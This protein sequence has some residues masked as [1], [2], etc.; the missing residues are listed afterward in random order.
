MAGGAARRASLMEEAS[1]L[2]A[3]PWSSGNR[4]RRRAVI[5]PPL[6]HEG[7][8]AFVHEREALAFLRARLPGREPYRAWTNVE[9]IADDGSVRG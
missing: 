5:N 8:S 7:A 2:G 9:F 1:L 6:W 3:L 4:C